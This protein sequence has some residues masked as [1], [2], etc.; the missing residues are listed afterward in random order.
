MRYLPF[1]TF[2]LL[3]VLS[4]CG[5][6]SP[7]QKVEGY[8]ISIIYGQPSKKGREI[9]G[10]LV[11]YGEV[12]RTGANEATEITFSRNTTFGGQPIQAGT[13][14]LFTIPQ[15]D[16]WT[17]ILNRALGQWGAYRY[18]ELK[19]HDVL[20]TEVPVQ[21]TD[22]IVEKLLFSIDSQ[23]ISIAWDNVRVLIPVQ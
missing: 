3:L 10:K 19:Q 21:R 6:E 23:G 13:Y 20:K 17:I 4:S 22:S 14:T 5:R 15:P 16:K 11:P 12:W 1:Y 2:V 9:F 18:T 8:G 7:R